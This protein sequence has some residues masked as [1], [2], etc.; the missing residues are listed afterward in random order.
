MSVVHEEVRESARLVHPR[1]AC[2][3]AAASATAVG[4]AEEPIQV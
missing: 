4:C 2:V 3:L 1:Q